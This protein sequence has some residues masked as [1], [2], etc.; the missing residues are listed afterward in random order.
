MATKTK[1]VKRK[2]VKKWSRKVNETSN[3]LDLETGIFTIALVRV[4]PLGLYCSSF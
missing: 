1:P 4:P 2:P 3:A